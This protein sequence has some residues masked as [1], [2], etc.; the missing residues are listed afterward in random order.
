MQTVFYPD[1]R[2]LRGELT[3]LEGKFNAKL[4]VS[5][6]I[7]GGNFKVFLGRGRGREIP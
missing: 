5:A 1:S 6:K 7:L 4:C 3:L 2:S